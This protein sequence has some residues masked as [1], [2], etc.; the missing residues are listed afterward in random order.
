MKNNKGH[1]S[2]IHAL[3]KAAIQSH[4]KGIE[5]L[6]E[7]KNNGNDGVEGVPAVRAKTKD[8]LVAVQDAI[9]QLGAEGT[10]RETVELGGGDPDVYSQILA[11]KKAKDAMPTQVDMTGDG[12]V[13]A[14]DVAA[15]AKDN[16]IEDED[17]PIDP[18]LMKPTTKLA[19]TARA[20]AG[21]TTP[22]DIEDEAKEAEIADY[23]A[24]ME[25]EEESIEGIVDRMM[26][27]KR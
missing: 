24:R 12:A 15:D 3:N 7:Q 13:D 6:K 1:Y 21:M 27:G 25:D 18:R 11:S 22:E 2:W 17:N 19:R 10:S 4:L 20:E 5:M 14:Q 23:E 16:N 8:Q 9:K 26:R